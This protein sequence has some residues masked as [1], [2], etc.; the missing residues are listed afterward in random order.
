MRV[1]IIAWLHESNTFISQQTTIEHFREDLLVTGSEVCQRLAGT[2]HEVGGFIE[3]LERENIEP[4]GIFAARAVPFGP[5]T[6]ETFEQLLESMLAELAK[7]GP[8]DGLLVA[9]HGATVSTNHPDMDGHWLSILRETVGAAM[10]ILGTFDP[11]ANLSQAMVDATNALVAYR[12]NPHLDQRERGLE[13]ATLMART[14][15]G[16]ITPVQVAGLPPMAINIECQHTTALPCL[17]LYE[18]ADHQLK[19]PGVL[20]NSIVL[21]F[22]YA[23]VAEMG[24]ATL[25][26]T[27]ND[28]PLAKQLAGDLADYLWTHRKDFDRPLLSVEEALDQ[29]TQLEGPVCLLDM[30]DNVGGGS[31]ADGTTLAHA[32][33]QRQLPNSLVCLYDPEAVE[34]AATAG[35][36]SAVPLSM[37]GKTDDLHGD[38]LVAKVTVLSLHEGKFT[39]PEPRHG[40]FSEMD[41][42][43][44]AVV[45]TITG[46]TILLN[47]KRTPPFSLQ[48]LISCRLDPLSFHLLVAKG[49]V[50][51]I[52][53]YAP[54]CN[55]F[56]RVNTPGV[57]TADM[58]SLSYQNRRQPMFPFE[59]ATQWQA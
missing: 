6:A 36:G 10:P 42:G 13:A 24:S 57:T 39:E 15:R 28:R 19:Q 38:P 35:V 48:Q 53:A 23:D 11:H 52:G 30:G 8:I 1:G 9:P 31:P 45:Q 55:H 46:L 4:V 3:G 12:S 17:P 41:Q 29:A 20:S 2:H 44:T 59:P 14:L 50:A 34:T 58:K 26:V 16:E 40:G 25:V 51:P 49:V 32:I 7:A 37:G 47:S 56:L 33:L 54:V 5:I 22:P 27:D 21:G 43:R 18:L